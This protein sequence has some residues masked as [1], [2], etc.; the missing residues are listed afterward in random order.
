LNIGSRT[1]LEFIGESF[2]IFN[3][4]NKR[5]DITNDGFANQAG[6]FVKVS[7]V[8]GVNIFP[9]YYQKPTNFLRATSSYAPRQI[10]LA[11]RLTF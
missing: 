10:Q 4:N 8:I 9:A 7:K 3:R 6:Q 5:M 1:K 2:N 11:I